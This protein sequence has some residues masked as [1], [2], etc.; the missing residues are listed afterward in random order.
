MTTPRNQPI[1]DSK[2]KTFSKFLW[3]DLFYNEE[4]RQF[5]KLANG[6]PRSFVQFV[7]EPWYKIITVSV[8]EEKA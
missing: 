5:T 2:V 8:S 4:T 6:L 1:F 3:G 7:L